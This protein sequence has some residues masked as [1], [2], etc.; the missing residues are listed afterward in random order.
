MI[1]PSLLSLFFHVDTV[2]IILLDIK[3]ANSGN[4]YR[5][6]RECVYQIKAFLLV[7]LFIAK[8]YL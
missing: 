7:N 5:K 4:V 6:T 2:H 1:A 8:I 3:T